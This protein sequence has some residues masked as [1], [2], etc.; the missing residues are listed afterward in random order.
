MP[1]ISARDSRLP[2]LAADLDMRATG[3]EVALTLA[4]SAQAGVVEETLQQYAVLA[5]SCCVLTKLDEC[6]SL[7][8]VLS[9]LMR[10]GLPL[11]YV[12]D[13]HSIPDDLRPARAI[14]LVA[15]AVTL[16]E[17]HGAV[18]DE[19]MLTRRFGRVGNASA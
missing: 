2:Q 13:G 6:S 12:S 17:R 18:A 3:V 8:G 4:A 10:T 1:G 19:E 5:P 14:E 7:G 11:S 16:A 9:G 15:L